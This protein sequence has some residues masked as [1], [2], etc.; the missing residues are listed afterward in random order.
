VALE[1]PPRSDS[2]PVVTASADAA[3]PSA[4]STEDASFRLSPPT[5]S[6]PKGGGAIRGV[7]E[8]FAAN[9]VT[10]SGSFS[11][12]LPV[13]PGR[14]GFGPQ[15]ALTYDSGNGNG[16]FGF[17]WS[18]SL[19]SISRKTDKGLPR[20]SDAT[21][22]FLISG[23]EDLVPILDANNAVDDD[24]TFAAG[25][26]IRRY[27]PRIEGL[28]ARIERWTRSDGDVHWRSISADNVLSIYG[29]DAD[30]R[31][32]DP[33]D[34]TRIFTWLICEVRDDK[35]NAIVYEYKAE[36]AAG[37]DLTQAHEQGRGGPGSR[38]RQTS[39]YIRRILYGNRR[40]LLDHTTH[41]RPRDLTASQRRNVDWMFEL[42]FDYGE[43]SGFEAVGAETWSCRP[44]LTASGQWAVRP[45][46]FSSYRAGFEIRTYRL[47]RRV[48]MLHH[49]PQ[50]DAVGRDCLV[51]SLEL[52]YRD[53]PED[54]THSNPG[55]SF[56]ERAA[57]RSYQR[58]PHDSARYR[59]RSLPPLEFHYTEANIDSSVR[60]PDVAELENLPVG[61]GDDYRL[62]DLDGEGLAGVLSEQAG[63][64]YYKSNLGAGPSGGPRFAPLRAVAP[65]PSLASATSRQQLMDLSGSGELAVVELQPPLP[66]FYERNGSDGWSNF[67]VFAQLP[68]VD[69]ADPNLRF[70]DLTGDGYADALITD[71]EVFTWYPSEATDGFGEAGRSA[72]ARDERDGPHVVFADEE[73]SIFLAD[74]S[75]DGL[76][77]IVRIRNGQ[78]SYWPNLGYGR[79]GHQV[80]M[81]SSPWFDAED[82]FDPRRIRL[83][84]VDGSGTAD[85][86][87]LGRG[88]A[89]LWFNRSGNEWSA[90][91]DLPFLTATSNVDQVQAADLLGN[92]TACLVWSSDLPRDAQRPMKYLDL[93]G[94]KKPH[95]LTR[96]VNNLGAETEV[97]Y[98]PS[99]KYYLEDKLAGTPWAT[100][101]PF[102]VHCVE[103]VTIR[104]RRRKTEYSTSY[105]YHHGCF[106]GPAEREFRGFG[107][108]E[109][110]DTERFDDFAD[111]NADS[112]YVT[113]DLELFQ[114]PVKTIT[115]F[116]TG[117]AVDRH[118][119]LG[120][121][122]HEYFPSR[123]ASRLWTSVERELPQ[124]EIDDDG[125]PLDTDEL[126][127]AM[128]ACKGMTLRQEVYE[129]DLDALE[130]R[131]EHRL[132]RLYSAAQHNCHVR[133]LQPRGP[134][135]H[136]V[137][138]V[139]ESEAVTYQYELP[140][141][142]TAPLDPDPRIAHT[143]NLRFDGYGRPRQSVAAAYPRR[144]S[145][146]DDPRD[147]AP[148]TAEQLAL[149]REVQSEP[150]VAYTEQEYTHELPFGDDHRLPAACQVRTYELTGVHPT[151]ADHGYLTPDGLRAL[152]LDPTLNAGA[153]RQV[154]PLDYQ[155]RP[156]TGDPHKR[157]V[158]H[159]VT[160]YFEDD[161]SGPRALE[162]PSR[163]G[164]TYESYK[165][166][167]TD[168]LL[169]D[170]LPSAPHQDAFAAEARAALGHAGA[171][172]GFL[173]SGYQRGAAILGPQ[174]AG[175]WWMRS[176]VARFDASAPD[177][178]YLPERYFDPFGNET[179]L[180]YDNDDLFVQ[181][182][183]D[184]VG[185]ATRVI[186]FDHRVL[187]PSRVEDLNWNVSAAAFDVFGL[188]VATAQMGKVSAG[189]P[190][191]SETGDTVEQV[192]FANLN[193]DPDRV[194]GF[195][196]GDPFDV[197]Q[198]RKWLGKA[199]ARFVYHFG[200]SID[201]H[202]RPVWGTTA[203]GAC[204]IV[205]ELHQRD[206]P[207]T[208]AA[209]IP[210]QASFEYSDGAGQ[211]FV[212]KIQAEPDPLHPERGIRWIANGKTI[213]NNKGNPVL[214]Y[215]PYFSDSAHRFEEPRPIGVAPIMYYDAPGRLI[216]TE[217]PDGSVSRV[218]V[219][220]W[221]SRSY[222]QNDTVLETANRWYAEH[223]AAV[224]E[225]EEKRA[226]RRAALHAGT[227][228]ETHF[229]SLG[230]SVVAIARNR[231]PDEANA[232]ATAESVADWPWKEERYFTFTKL[233][234]EGK[235]LWICDALGNLVMQYNAR[236]RPDHTPLYDTV[237]RDYHPA[238]FMPPSSVPG[239]DVAGNLL[240]QHS[241]DA[242]DR[243]MLM[244]AAGQPL[245]AWDYNERKDASTPRL[246]KEHRRV[247]VVYDA[248][249]RPLERWLRVR[250]E[251]TGASRES[252]VERFR[253]GEGVTNAK[254]LNLRGKVWQHYDC[255]GVAQTDEFDLSE[256]PRVLRR[257]LA[258]DIE[259]PVHDWNGVQLANVHVGTAAAFEGDVFTLRTDYDALGRATRIYNWHVESPNN[260]GQSDRVAVY[261][262]SYN[263]R[264][265]LAAETL[266]VRARKTPGG[267]QVVAGTTRSQDAIKRIDYDAK[268][269]RT[270][271]DCGN[272]TVT[273]YDYDAKTF[274]LRVLRT[275][276][277]GYN[278][279][280]PSKR[281][282]LADARVLQHLFYNYDASGNITEIQ[283][284]AWAPAFFDNQRVEAASR[285]VYDSIGR[286]VEATGRENGRASG[287]P[288]QLPS[289]PLSVA[290]FPVTS[291]D[292]LRNYIERYRY[293]AV[294]NIRTMRHIAG[295]L[296]SWTRT[297]DYAAASNQLTG[298]DTDNPAR[299]VTYDYD[300]HGSML[301]LSSAPDRFDLRWDWNDMIHTIDL[302]GGGR[303][304]YQYSA[305]KQRCRKRIDRQN[306]TSGYRERIY[307]PGFE[308][309]RRTANDPTDPVEEIE[310]HHL[311]AARQRVLLVDDV[312]KMQNPRP[313][314]S[315]VRV[316]TLWRYHYTTH[317]GS[318]A[319]E[320]D[321]TGQVIS[322][323]EFGPYGTSAFRSQPAIVEAPT[324]RYRYGGL[325]RDEES[326]LAPHGL[327]Y[328][329]PALA[330]WTA[331]DPAGL[332]DGPHVYTYCHGNPINYGD[333]RGTQT[334][335]L[336]IQTS[337]PSARLLDQD[338]ASFRVSAETQSAVMTPPSPPSGPESLRAFDAYFRG[339]WHSVRAM[340]SVLGTAIKWIGWDMWGATMYNITGGGVDSAYRS[341]YT[342]S[343]AVAG[344]IKSFL[345]A[346][347]KAALKAFLTPL[348]RMNYWI[349]QGNADEAA[350]AVG[351]W[352]PQA[353]AALDPATGP[354]LIDPLPALATDTIAIP[355]AA[356]LNL[357]SLGPGMAISAMAVATG[358]TGPTVSQGN[359]LL[360]GMTPS[361]GGLLFQATVDRASQFLFTDLNRFRLVLS[362]AEYALGRTQ[363]WAA[364]VF[365]GTGIERYTAELIAADDLPFIREGGPY[366]PDFL[367]IR[368]LS[369]SVY[370]VYPFT[371]QAHARHMARVYGARLGM[372][373]GR[374]L[375]PQGFGRLP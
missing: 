314:G 109:Q 143:V 41:L 227:P 29:K 90:G 289:G 106:D 349:S 75:G 272:G 162:L 240:F 261:L 207:N 89:R 251:S 128:R 218:E 232:P 50:D 375:W 253:Y 258:S 362:Q 324:K 350:Y 257:R 305:D 242:G 49:F 256:K 248:L 173:A 372:F 73:Q 160:L 177:H 72:V 343:Q 174:G 45:D 274:R 337:R 79:F 7:G 157:L 129:L 150:H 52:A 308:L 81:D 14:G 189:P 334:T 2:S 330:R 283:D 351:E 152:R 161:L 321:E 328:Y 198:A 148:L 102:P 290:G 285:Y 131:H 37:I 288:P 83:A 170:V 181:S 12:P 199:T 244:D 368:E 23:A 367:G 306:G 135:R 235:P 374:Y 6:L 35:G 252:L 31:I 66:G 8:K 277:P 184:A 4:R 171:R 141:G 229:D 65:L 28:F 187:A 179:S 56:L 361:R 236:P 124:P 166:A 100:R 307:L 93:L 303:A 175:Q 9:P 111:A 336:S 327:R 222:D 58:D 226:A 40:S 301:N 243:R 172:A 245:L 153:T 320:L 254:R 193:P 33:S 259:A 11:V 59:Y 138:L 114:P 19:P 293:D 156:R 87:Y 191:S 132:V 280:F 269:Q 278:P 297:Y 300:K 107:R 27:R 329:A 57:Q 369:G 120:L 136:S 22:T 188:P 39:R 84:D 13:S 319:A 15:L 26:V 147:P 220:P 206:A 270:R 228:A 5:V 69:W 48:L 144:G 99:T 176:G 36:D 10:G 325:E 340:V 331:A 313:D 201:A 77:D 317:L 98:A 323:E 296:G 302:G 204:G 348:D 95:L 24:D 335:P 17:G 154:V 318:V 112:P 44:D 88:G 38:T 363:Y 281:G 210:I 54:R 355:S 366:N 104:D 61:L 105:S 371:P 134:N 101:L 347:P 332:S 268:G 71:D 164:L 358:Q 133:R 341:Q 298:T 312:L 74:M 42:V 51:R 140:L 250:D 3:E 116:H 284:D 82:L 299:A 163:L 97:E 194:A 322:F 53:T 67:K 233:D 186:R 169:D 271:L 208:V 130:S 127:E 260:S 190:E 326:G 18:L 94:G 125:S 333:L 122:E 309:Y 62:V 96:M 360:T 353:L 234:A 92:G 183:I 237:G 20:F 352:V 192:S 241:M 32:H 202:G 304:W 180:A 370:D 209:Q 216:R 238:Y 291:P 339:V 108:V 342:A 91:R 151:A 64:W 43:R 344:N 286:L 110:V 213:V 225:L 231:S 178:F 126:R 46:P 338:E 310:S 149:I 265:L 266:L 80:A 264:G 16:V 25:Y 86:I 230:R 205:R 145:Y 85:L 263:E 195:F 311:F 249:H 295:S 30:S 287:A 223:T 315:R 159:A 167:L 217:F 70:V 118:R 1:P 364:R 214:Q 354:R 359:R 267:H 247:R 121:F 215:E 78:V 76:S 55:F 146:V 68:N 346:G 21:D 224:A 373:P 239:Y 255:S 200:E 168:S 115:W 279:H 139:T 165:L 357:G 345:I 356:T 246:F 212:K 34:P 316:R 196:L 365:A 182:S 47:C 142:G 60:D 292:A 155:Q 113:S 282:Q 197:D 275:T 219:S 262:P 203:A 294:G 221:L 117:I 211:A 103:K 273:Q 185:N 276:R 119:I 63:A 123:F 158:E 137:F